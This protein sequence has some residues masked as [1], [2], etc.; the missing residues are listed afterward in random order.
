MTTADNIPSICTIVVTYNAEDWIEP[1]LKSLEGSSY[2][3]TVIVVDNASTDSTVERIKQEFGDVELI[4]SDENMGFGR[5]NNC[6]IERALRSQAKYVFLLNQDAKVNN[7]CLEKLIECAEKYNDYGI[8]S[9]MHLSYEGDEVDPHFVG[10]L[11]GTTPNVYSDL[12]F[13]RLQEIYDATFLPAAAW[14][15]R[16]EALEKVGGFDPLFFMYGEDCDLC[17]RMSARNFRIGLVPK[18]YAYH[19]H[20]GPGGGQPT[21]GEIARDTYWQVVLWLKDPKTPFFK[22]L[23]NIF[24]EYTPKLLHKAIYLEFAGVYG[25]VRGLTQA[26]IKLPKIWL[27]RKCS[28][29]KD[30]AF[31][32]LA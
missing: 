23:I 5:A 17:R 31:L 27:H 24:R 3:S 20:G 30:A 16:L 7:D 32:K 2:P 25:I 10:Y 4:C 14:L 22:T 8:L 28:T 18:A 9:P 15:V 6:A 13:S 29:E 21:V 11:N 1:C 12:L 26:I 19:F